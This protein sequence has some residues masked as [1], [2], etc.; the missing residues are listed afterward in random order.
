MFAT[1]ISVRYGE[2][3]KMGVVYHANY[4][5]WFEIG[6]EELLKVHGMTYAEAEENGVMMPLTDCHAKFLCGAR[7]GDEV[8][9][10][11]CMEKQ[12]VVRCK[13]VYKAYRENDNVLL[14]EGY[15]THCFTNTS[16]EPIN[17]KKT[18]PKF[19]D[20]LCKINGEQSCRQEVE[21]K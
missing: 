17:L 21:G 1:K 4:F 11:V 10:E 15:T 9:I 3:D 5:P 2:T 14:A 19:Y 12:T 18:Y 20:V 7:Y 16:M 13:F 8:R 6:R